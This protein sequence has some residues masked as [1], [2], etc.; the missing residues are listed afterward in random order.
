MTVDI[1]SL[2]CQTSN[3]GHFFEL[4]LTFSVKEEDKFWFSPLG[5]WTPVTYVCDYKV[6]EEESSKRKIQFVPIYPNKDAGSYLQSS[7]PAMTDDWKK[8]FM[9]GADMLVEANGEYTF[10]EFF[11][12]TPVTLSIVEELKKLQANPD[13]TA[14]SQCAQVPVQY[15]SSLLQC[16]THFWD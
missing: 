2:V 10:H 3:N 16:L 8:G 5:E 6:H 12:I 15:L 4:T 13:H 7:G 1:K 9:N 14:T 11:T